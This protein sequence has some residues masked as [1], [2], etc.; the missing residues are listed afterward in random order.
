[1][2]TFFW[3]D[4]KVIRTMRNEDFSLGFAENFGKFMILRRDI[5]KIRSLCKFFRVGLNI[6]RVKTELKLARA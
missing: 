3:I 4:L 5:G 2:S 6:R 1:L